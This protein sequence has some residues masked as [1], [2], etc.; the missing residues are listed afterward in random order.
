MTSTQNRE[1]QIE[2]PLVT[3]D[4]INYLLLFSEVEMLIKL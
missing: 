1:A 2:R 3:S 4:T